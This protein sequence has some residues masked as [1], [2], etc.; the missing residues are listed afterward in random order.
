MST[1]DG[2]LYGPETEKALG[3]FSIAGRPVDPALIHAY[4]H[5]KLAAA[6]TNA[7]L[8][9]LPEDVAQPLFRAAREMIRGELDRHIVV[10]ALQGGA[11]TSLNMNV[12]EVL[13]R[14]ATEPGGA[15][16]HPLDHV[17]LH[18]STNDTFPTAL[19]VAAIFRGRALENSLLA[20]QEAL[21]KKEVEFGHLVKM[22]RTQLRDAV[23]TTLGRSFGAWAEA[24]SRDRWRISRCEERLRVVNLGGTA[25]GTGLGAP[26]EYIFQVTE[27][28]KKSTGIGFARAENLIEATQNTDA[29]AEVSGMLSVCGAD[30]VKI[31]CDLRLLSS[32]PDAGL[33]EISLPA[34]QAGSSIMPGKVNPVIPE[35]AVQAGLMAMGNHSALCH[36]CALGNLELNPFMPLIAHTLLES[37][38]MLA[39]AGEKLATHCV[40]GITAN[41]LTLERHATASTAAVTALIQRT[42]YTL[43]QEI[44]ERAMKEGISIRQ[45]AVESGIT[46]SEY[47]H[48]T[49]P[50]AVTRLGVPGRKP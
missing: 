5:V 34:L 18:Q 16:I 41:P 26:R 35:A 39:E 38:R 6:F 15:A 48:L 33:G 19:R 24:V 25:I 31:S 50:E 1:A 32:G 47:D 49:S 13:A 42:G 17:N 40:P 7:A 22:G 14:R 4:G 8:G 3:N 29:F 28:L 44:A 2:F 46:E 12:N 27:N 9:Y 43:A 20:L 30:L 23:L 45:A 21:Q 37:Q 10:D 11:G 36:A